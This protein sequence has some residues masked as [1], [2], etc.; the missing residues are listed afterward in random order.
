[1]N[2]VIPNFFIL[3]A[4]RCGTTALAMYLA[5]CDDIC[6]SNPKEPYYFNDGIWKRGFTTLEDYLQCFSHMQ[7][8]HLLVG[9]GSV[10]YF[11][12]DQTV[13]NILAFNPNAK[14]IVMLRNPIDLIYS[15]HGKLLAHHDENI[16]DF[17]TAW[18][19][20]NDR[21][22]GNLIPSLCN[23]PKVLQ[24]SE[25]GKIGT[26]LNSL[27]K[28]IDKSKIHVII[29]DDLV[30]D[31]QGELVKV[32]KFLGSS[33]SHANNFQK[34]NAHRTVTSGVLSKTLKVMNDLK[35]KTPILRSLT[36]GLYDKFYQATSME[37]SRTNLSDDFRDKLVEV[38]RSEVELL[39]VMLGR[40]FSYWLK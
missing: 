38:Y 25:M 14:F 37:S 24:Y 27:T 2:N 7:E 20:Q 9:E 4:P 6:F 35:M 31:P 28:L 1:M 34:E 5:K 19:A 15:L 30:S 18:N 10:F 16:S 3:G 23:D 40:D 33:Q 39:S 11:Y 8:K 17:E 26:R 13:R 32:L 29:Y 36:F 21:L 12:S 22:K